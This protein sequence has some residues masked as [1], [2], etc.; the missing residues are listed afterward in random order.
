MS[1]SS[2][3]TRSSLEIGVASSVRWTHIAPTLLIVWVVSMFD[4]SNMAIVMNDQTFLADLGLKGEQAKAAA[5]AP[6]PPPPP[7]SKPPVKK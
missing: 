7:P 1:S 2:A 4:K 3:G 6:P 5:N